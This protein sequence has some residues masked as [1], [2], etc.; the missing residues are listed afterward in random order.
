[1][2]SNYGIFVLNIEI[3]KLKSKA[4]MEVGTAVS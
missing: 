1:M 4:A 3:S 2:E